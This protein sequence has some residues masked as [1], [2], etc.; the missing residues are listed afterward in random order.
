MLPLALLPLQSLGQPADDTPERFSRTLADSS[1]E[2]RCQVESLEKNPAAT[3]D[4][5]PTALPDRRIRGAFLPRDT[6]RHWLF[7]GVAGGGFLALTA[8][9]FSTDRVRPAV[10]VRV[11]LYTATAGVVVMLAVQGMIA[12]AC[13]AVLDGDGDFVLS[14][15]GYVL[16]VGLIEEAAKVLPLRSAHEV[17]A[18]S[19]GV[20]LVFG[21]W[22]PASGLVSPRAW[23]TPSGSTTAWSAARRRDACR[24]GSDSVKRRRPPARRGRAK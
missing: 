19:A 6:V 7:A 22:R 14:L 15:C 16:G 12:P 5:A 2:V 18:L 9:L 21:A 4:D 11:S 13:E 23:S 10:L 17:A 3:L 8:G 20:P 24:R 1:A